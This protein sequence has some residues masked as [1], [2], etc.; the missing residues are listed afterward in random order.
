MDL[1]KTLKEKR[2]NVV[3][4]NKTGPFDKS[5]KQSVGQ[6]V[7]HMCW[8]TAFWCTS[9]LLQI[10]M[11]AMAAVYVTPFMLAT[12]AV[13]TGVTTDTALLDVIA[14]WF[15]PSMFIVLILTVITLLGCF[16]LHGGLR[17]LF[18]YC[19]QVLIQ[20]ALKRNK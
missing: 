8:M 11:C 3:S 17:K 15:F 20:F 18:N 2:T 1:I 16:N 6:V 14:F 5:K 7:N 10:S 12:L 19:E 4:V 13:A 9:L